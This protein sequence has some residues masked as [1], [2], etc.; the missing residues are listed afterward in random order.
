MFSIDN[1]YLE[2]I[3]NDALRVLEEIGVKCNS[4]EIRRIFEDT[5]LAA[6]DETTGHIHVLSPLVA[7]A[8]NTTPKRD[9]YWIGENAFGVG[10]TAPF[11]YDDDSGEL[12]HKILSSPHKAQD[13]SPIAGKSTPGIM[14][15]PNVITKITADNHISLSIDTSKVPA[16]L[17]VTYHK[18]TLHY[19]LLYYDGKEWGKKEYRIGIQNS[20][21]YVRELSLIRDFYDKLGLVYYVTS[22]NAGSKSKGELHF[23]EIPKTI[24]KKKERL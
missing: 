2:T 15:D 19:R 21:Q 5:G 6:F 17:V 10:G 9:Q 22:N 13:W 14:I 12:R 7:Q 24:F 23:Q 1:T 4:T 20:N 11:V 3:H 18:E 8:L 16:H